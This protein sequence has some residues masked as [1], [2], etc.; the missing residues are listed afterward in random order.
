[1][2]TR[3]ATRN[4]YALVRTLTGALCLLA[5]ACSG[6][7]SDAGSPGGP[8]GPGTEPSAF[9]VTGDFESGSF[10]ALP[11]SDPAD[12]AVDLGPLHGDAVARSFGGLVY[13]VNRFGADNIQAIDPA[14]GWRTLFQCSVGN[15][16]NPHDIAF[17]STD[18]AYVT[19]Y[20][21]AHLLIVDPTVGPTCE[22]FERGRIDLTPFADSDGLPEMDQMAVVDGKLFVALQRLDRNRFFEPSGTSTLVVIDT[23]TDTFIDTRP[24]T[25]GVDPIALRWTNPLG[26]S[27][28]LPIDPASGEIIVVQLGS[29]GELGDG[30]VETIHPTTFE[31]GRVLLSEEDLGLNLTDVAVVDG[32]IAWVIGTDESFRN[33]VVQVDMTLGEPLRTLFETDVYL[34]DLE[35][36]PRHGTIWLTDRT[37]DAAGIRIFDAQDGSGF[38]TIYATGLPPNDIVFVE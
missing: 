16:T 32:R 19:L 6:G 15:G 2:R 23:E 33:F 17:V 13:V 26:A 27:R 9:V 1:M 18:K 22:G 38:E 11:L 29:F 35:F 28:G 20:E 7:G 30:G 37:F 31:H 12:G 25:P 5:A 4:R 21:E 10:A 8:G 34:T 3:R 14:Q 24:E 36:E